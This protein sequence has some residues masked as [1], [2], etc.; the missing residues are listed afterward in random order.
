MSYEEFAEA[1]KK[2]VEDRI[3]QGKSV[4][5]KNTKKNNGKEKMG[6]VFCDSAVNVAPAIYLEEY[7]ERYRQGCD[8]SVI[9]EQILDLYKEVKVRHPWKT[10]FVT[11]FK[12]VRSRLVYELINRDKNKELLKEIPYKNYLDLA[13]IFRVL[14]EMEGNDRF[15]TMLVRREHLDWWGVT[16]E[17]IYREAC[18]NTRELLPAEFLPLQSL[19]AQMSPGAQEEIPGQDCSDTM[20]VLTNSMRSYGAAAILYKDSLKQIADFVEQDFYVLPSSVHEVIILPET[21]APSSEELCMI[22]REMNQTQVKEEE[23]LSDTAYWYDKKTGIL[24]EAG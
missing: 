11:D 18:R 17:D 13:V 1:V 19:I 22:V 15:A 23:V 5:L 3:G 14:L 9:A 10:D 2:Q 24:K 6:L 7:Y 8:I 4:Y 21:C 16:E 20:Y 12:Q